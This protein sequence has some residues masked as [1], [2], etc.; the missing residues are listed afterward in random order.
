MK[1]ENLVLDKEGY[2]RI[3]DFGIARKQRPDN[4]NDTSGTPGY[5]SPEVIFRNNH[6]YLA[7]YYAVGVVLYELM[8]GRRP[9]HGNSR[10]E[11]RDD[12]VSRQAIVRKSDLHPDW[13]PHV[14]DFCSKVS[15]RRANCEA[16]R[17]EAPETTWR[18]E[19]RARPKA[20]PLAEGLR[21]GWSY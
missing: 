11:I 13:S 21:L 6:N 18:L 15:A 3:T 16:A 10:K 19:W 12:I 2:L 17:E 7:D 8:F 14:A 20:A 9:Y 4:G 1:P 5:M